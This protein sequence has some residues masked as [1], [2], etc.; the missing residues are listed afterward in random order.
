[1]R[2]KDIS[3]NPQ[4]V[5]R[6]IIL[7]EKVT[8]EDIY[9]DFKRRHPHLSLDAVWWEPA[10]ILRIDIFMKD[11]STIRYDYTDHRGCFLRK[12]WK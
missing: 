7:N 11:G 1:M 6:V 4:E 8:Y 10:D 3:S 5:T 12:R 2:R 9:K